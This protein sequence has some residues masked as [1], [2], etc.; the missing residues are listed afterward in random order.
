MF[1]FDDTLCTGV[2]VFHYPAGYRQD[3]KNTGYKKATEFNAMASPY[4]KN[5]FLTG[6]W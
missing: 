5:I 4:T 6:S 2:L 3:S 1:A